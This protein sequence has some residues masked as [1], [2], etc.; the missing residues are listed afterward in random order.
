MHFGFR[1]S[2]TDNFLGTEKL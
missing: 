2:S 1:N